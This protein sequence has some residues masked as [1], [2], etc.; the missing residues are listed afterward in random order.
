MTKNT[1]IHIRLSNEELELLKIT[2]S[3]YELTL[4]QFILSVLIP[5]CVKNSK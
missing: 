2:A 4:S 1:Q 5:F 3:K